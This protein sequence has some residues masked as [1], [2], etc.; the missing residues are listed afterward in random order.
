MHITHEEARTLIQLSLDRILQTAEKNSLHAHLYECMECQAYANEIKEVET[1]LVPVMKKQWS[2]APIPFSLATAMRRNKKV[3]PGNFLAIRKAAISLVAAALFF[4]AWQF[5]TSR[6][7]AT[8]E[9][10]LTVLPI[11]TPSGQ[12][13]QFTST[14]DTCEM[15]L[16][17][18]QENDTLTGI[19]GRFWVTEEEIRAV[20]HLTSGEVSAA[21]QLVIPLCNFTPT[22]TVHPAT[23]TIT[24]TPSTSPMT[25][26]PGG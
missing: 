16:Y 15:M 5:V 14:T 26:T 4:S 1:V 24:Y 21:M 6:P 23:F 11:P 18:V 13:A 20:N 22:G 12:T 2:L 9:M 7:S 19:A 10:P 3:Q 17:T 8:G 25:S